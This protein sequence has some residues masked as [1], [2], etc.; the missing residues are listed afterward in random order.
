M[1][2][3]KCNVNKAI[4]C[5]HKYKHVRDGKLGRIFG[6]SKDTIESSGRFSVSCVCLSYGTQT[7]GSRMTAPSLP[8]FLLIL[9]LCLII[10]FRNSS[11]KSL[12][13]HVMSLI[14]LLQVQLLLFLLSST[15]TESRH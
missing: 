14:V 4:R 6:L 15:A 12:F 10:Y 13:N 1:R 5:M 11:S 3:S 7:P 9:F 8:W 2:N